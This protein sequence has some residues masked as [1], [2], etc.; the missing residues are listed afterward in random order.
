MS[1]VRSSDNAAERTIRSRLWRRG[2]RFRLQARNLIGR[3]DIVLPRYRAVVF[4]DGDYWHGRALLE[5]GVRALRQVIRGSRFE[6][7]HEKL[8]ANIE[9]DREVT[10]QLTQDGWL[11]LRI[12]ESEVQVDVDG[13]VNR[14][15]AELRKRG[16]HFKYSSCDAAV[17]VCKNREE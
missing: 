9:R 6:W 5:G 11:V 10:R 3:P 2:F 15:E 7:W 16:R 4:V 17:T 13:V 1:A 8:K 12:W 14:L